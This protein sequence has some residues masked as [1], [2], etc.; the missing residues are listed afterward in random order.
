MFSASARAVYGERQRSCFNFRHM[1][2]ALESPSVVPANMK[3][4]DRHGPSFQDYSQFACDADVDAK[5]IA[6]VEAM[7]R[8]QAR[9]ENRRDQAAHPAKVSSQAARSAR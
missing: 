7:A 9:R 1:T 4:A 2:L 5:L 6:L 8:A 3:K